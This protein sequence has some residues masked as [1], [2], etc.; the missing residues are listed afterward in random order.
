MLSD[1]S[2]M[3]GAPRLAQMSVNGTAKKLVRD[4]NLS[5]LYH[6]EAGP[7]ERV[8]GACLSVESQAR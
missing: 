5:S 3:K 4:A 6:D 1:G 8:D 2:V 7:H